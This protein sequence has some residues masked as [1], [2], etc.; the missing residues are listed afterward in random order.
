MAYNADLATALSAAPQLGTLSATTRPSS[1]QGTVMWTS[2]YNKVRASFRKAR[3]SDAPD[4]GSLAEGLAQRAEMLLTSGE[5]LLSIGRA[6]I[7]KGGLGPKAVAAGRDLIKDA[8]ACLA[9][10]EAGHL[11]L[12]GEGADAEN[13][14]PTRFVRSHQIDDA[15]PDFDRTPGTGDIDYSKMNVWPQ[16]Q[17]TF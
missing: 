2:A 17:D 10:I 11:W 8:M 4:V 13:A 12:V 14:N 1:T 16:D 3:L 6:T 5:V 9:E 7:G 15:D